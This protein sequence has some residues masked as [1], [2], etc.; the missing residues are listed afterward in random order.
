[1]STKLTKRNERVRLFK[2]VKK[3]I[4]Q[5]NL[6]SLLPEAPNDEFDYE[7]RKIAGQINV[8]STV[9]EIVEI[10]AKVFSKAFDEKSETKKYMATA[11]K[12]YKSMKNNNR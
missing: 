6:Y 7:S 3:A 5:F 8:N 1:L 12:I 9:E 10:I 4:D 2:I 11:E